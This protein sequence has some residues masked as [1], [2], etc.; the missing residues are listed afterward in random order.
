MGVTIAHLGTQTQTTIVAINED[1][2]IIDQMQIPMKVQRLTMQDFMAVGKEILNVRQQFA[3][4]YA[5]PP[6]PIAPSP[7]N[8]PEG[9][10]TE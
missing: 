10:S 2:E 3:T 6:A 5:P 9:T 7:P 1:G 4:K 8:S